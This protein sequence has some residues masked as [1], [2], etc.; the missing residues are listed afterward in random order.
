MT[1]V[2]FLL[3]EYVISMKIFWMDIEFK[4][5]ITKTQSPKA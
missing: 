5:L 1:S 3:P 4:V 2:K